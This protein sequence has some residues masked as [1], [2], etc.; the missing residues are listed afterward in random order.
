MCIHAINA[1]APAIL[2]VMARMH[3]TNAPNMYKCHV[4]TC[5]ICKCTCSTAS[6]RMHFMA[7][8]RPVLQ[9]AS[10]RLRCRTYVRVY[11]SFPR[12]ISVCWSVLWCVVTRVAVVSLSQRCENVLWCVAVYLVLL[13]CVGVRCSVLQPASLQFRCI[14]SQCV[15]V[16]C[17]GLQCV[18]V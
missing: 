18:A 11:C 3:T 15:A 2:Q 8:M 16:C 5:Q 14:V 10:L 1:N 13:Q 12:Y 4:Y 7:R 9:P 17:S 6:L